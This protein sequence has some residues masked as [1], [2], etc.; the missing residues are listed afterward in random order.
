VKKYWHIVNEGKRQLSRLFI[1]TNADF[2]L[3]V[4]AKNLTSSSIVSKLL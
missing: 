3:A 1:V 4:A 2:Y